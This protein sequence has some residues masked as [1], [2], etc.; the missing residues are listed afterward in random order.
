[1]LRK[2]S[3]EKRLSDLRCARPDDFDDVNH[4]IMNNKDGMYAWRPLELVHPALYVSLVNAITEKDNWKHIIK[5]F[6]RF[7]RNPKIRCLSIPVESLTKQKDRAE[8]ITSWWIG[9]EQRS[10]E[11]TLDYELL[12]QT[13]IVDCYPAF[14][15]HSIS[16][17]LHG[18]KKAK[19][20]RSDQTMIGNKNR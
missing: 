9:V 19:K 17:A 20:N 15:T 6:R 2:F 16:W 12:V 11:L 18:K 1:M 5:R 14:Y 10:L 13:D 7:G 3:R 4:L 8:Q